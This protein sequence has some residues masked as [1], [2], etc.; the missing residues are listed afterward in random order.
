MKKF[1]V[2]NL[3]PHDCVLMN[4]NQDVILKIGKSGK[5][6]RCSESFQEPQPIEVNGVCLNLFKKIV[7]KTY[8]LPEPVDGVLY[9]VSSFVASDNPNRKDL[10]TPAKYVR[11][12]GLT[13]GCIDFAVLTVRHNF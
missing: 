2:V 7:G 10:I 4:E 5:I 6:A 12:N 13:I 9:F 3:T 8:D 1:E 11:E